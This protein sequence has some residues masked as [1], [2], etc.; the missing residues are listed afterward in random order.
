MIRA[1]TA[2]QRVEE[3]KLISFVDLY[4]KVK[5]LQKKLPDH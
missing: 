5:K 1:E 2:D 3:N 4:T